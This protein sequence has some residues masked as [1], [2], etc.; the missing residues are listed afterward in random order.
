[1]V[2]DH[3]L[4]RAFSWRQVNGIY[5]TPR[6]SPTMSRNA[7]FAMIQQ[8]TDFQ[9]IERQIQIARLKLGSVL[10]Y[11]DC[12]APEQRVVE[13]IRDHAADI[14]S[15]VDRLLDTLPQLSSH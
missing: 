6:G 10:D 7:I 15:E 12:G 8:P 2:P 13:R 1:M 11:L 9:F 14:A 4:V 3:V 5:F